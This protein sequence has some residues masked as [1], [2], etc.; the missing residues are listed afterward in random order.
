VNLA[1]YTHQAY[2]FPQNACGWWGLSTVGGT[3]SQSWFNGNLELAVTGHELG[4]AMGLWH[5]HS[6][7]CGSVTICSNG[8][9]NEYGDLIDIMGASH[10]AQYNAFQK[11]RLGWLNAGVSP[12]ITTVVADGTY[13][14][15]AYETGSGPKAL[16]I[17]KS[18][19]P[20]TGV[21]TWYYVESRQAVGFDSFLADVYKA[22]PP[23]NVTSGVLVHFGS[24]SNGNFN[25]LLDMTP[26]TSL[27]YGW[28]DPALAAGQSFAD[29]DTG[30]TI[31][32]SWVSATGAG[33]TVHV[34]TPTSTSLS[35]VSV[36]TNQTSYVRGQ[37][38]SITAKV[39]SGGSPVA[40]AAV[41]FT[42]I[43][44]TGA[45]VTANATTGNNGTAVYK[46]RLKNQDPV[47]TYEADANATTNGQSAKGATTF[48]VQ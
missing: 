5:S 46:L 9:T 8:L 26:M 12:P 29:P 31:T 44:P 43:K 7:E 16:K 25:F 14:I 36:S 11:E 33:V 34:G 45:K 6:L 35:T 21:K 24:E 13:T 15:N 42:V 18:T 1:S 23:Q 3:P 2:A 4:H 40:K 41:S 28:Y 20:I 32:T 39:S 48:T 17:L 38:A 30:L 10:S 47:G 19:D 37:T 22:P 27:S